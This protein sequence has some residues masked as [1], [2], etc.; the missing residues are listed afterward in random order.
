MYKNPSRRIRIRHFKHWSICIEC[1]PANL[2]ICH[3]E[4]IRRIYIN[5]ISVHECCI[6]V[7]FVFVHV[8]SYCICKTVVLVYVIQV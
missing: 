1:I 7:V 6:I 5:V 3:Y 8:L 2:I 4:E